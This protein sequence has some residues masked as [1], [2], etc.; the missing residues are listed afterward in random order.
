MVASLLVFPPPAGVMHR[1]GVV[2]IHTW[3]MRNAIYHNGCIKRGMSRPVQPS[4]LLLYMYI[5]H[6]NGTNML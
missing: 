3:L 2:G 4:L 5:F 1:G 6:G